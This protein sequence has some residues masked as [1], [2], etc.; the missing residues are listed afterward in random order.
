MSKLKEVPKINL[1]YR[2]CYSIRIEIFRE[3]NNNFKKDIIYICILYWNSRFQLK[4]LSPRIKIAFLSFQ[5]W[6]EKKR[7]KLWESISMPLVG[8]AS[9]RYLKGL[10][11]ARKWSY[12][13]TYKEKHVFKTRSVCL[14]WQRLLGRSKNFLL[15]PKRASPQKHVWVGKCQPKHIRNQWNSVIVAWLMIL[16]MA[17]R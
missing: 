8:T 12:A 15:P 6:Q 16:V 13:K 1:R 2:L 7:K 9:E 17:I 14:G 3:E 5:I 4:K 10:T 11:R